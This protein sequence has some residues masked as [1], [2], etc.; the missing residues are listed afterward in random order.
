MPFG[1]LHS[2]R[3]FTGAL[4]YALAYFPVHW[5]V[6]AIAYMDD[7]PYLHQS[8]V[9]LELATPQI[10]FYLQSLGWTL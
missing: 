2:P 5:E 3:V 8:R 7:V 10:G 4:G 9:Y 1:A 6:R